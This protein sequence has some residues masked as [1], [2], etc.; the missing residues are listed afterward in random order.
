[1]NEEEL[2]QQL[3]REMETLSYNRLHKL[4]NEAIAQGLI[5]GHGY[6]GG[7]YEILRKEEELLLDPEK[8]E[9]YLED[10]LN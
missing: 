1:M 2:R 9:K 4:G 10:L 3:D 6:R 7:K 5:I 8:A